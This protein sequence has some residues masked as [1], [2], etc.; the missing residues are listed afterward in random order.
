MIKSLDTLSVSRVSILLLACI[1][2][3]CRHWF[4]K[5]P[6]VIR[7]QVI[8]WT[9]EIQKSLKHISNV[10]FYVHTFLHLILNHYPN[11][12]FMLRQVNY[13]S[14]WQ[15]TK[16]QKMLRI[17]FIADN[18]LNLLIDAALVRLVRTQLQSLMHQISWLT[19]NA[20]HS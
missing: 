8:I 12:T 7:S 5:W 10:S 19:L 15:S 1:A 17:A 14:N 18:K 16:W 2:G 3:L 20:R 9:I 6:V 13:R 11:V 4:K